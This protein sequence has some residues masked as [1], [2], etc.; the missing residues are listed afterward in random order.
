VSVGVHLR[1]KHLLSQL[2]GDD[3]KCD[4]EKRLSLNINHDEIA[5]R[6]NRTTHLRRLDW[7]LFFD[8]KA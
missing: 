2:F 3:W 4:R 6:A 5:D 1:L 7:M 8:F